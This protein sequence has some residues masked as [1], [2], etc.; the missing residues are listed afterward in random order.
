MDKK[1]SRTPPVRLT[2]EESAA[3]E[4]ALEN[5]RRRTGRN[6]T[7][8]AIVREAIERFCKTEGVEYPT[9]GKTSG[10]TAPRSR[11]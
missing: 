3:I 7:Q 8:T 11:R 5:Y 9:R 10:K 6:K 2:P 4:K 1:L